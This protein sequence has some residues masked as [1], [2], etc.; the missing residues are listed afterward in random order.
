[1]ESEV[2]HRRLDAADPESGSEESLEPPI[3]EEDQRRGRDARSPRAIGW[4]GWVDILHRVFERVGHDHLG[5]IAAGVTFY[6]FFAIVPAMIALATLYGIVADSETLAQHLAILEGYLPDQGIHW[7]EDELSR[8]TDLREQGLTLTFLLS[9]A[10]SLWSMNNAVVAIFAAM[11]VAYREVE[12][13]SFITLYLETF[14]FTLAGLVFGLVLITAFVVLPLVLTAIGA[15]TDGFG[16]RLV[17]APILFVAVLIAS[18][19]IFRF[20]PSRRGARWTWISVGSVVVAGGWLAAA[21]LM[22]WYLSSIADYSRI[23]GSLGAIMAL[24]FWIYMSVYVLCLGG[25]L[26]AEIEHQTRIDTTI[27]P[28]KPLGKRGAFVADTIGKAAFD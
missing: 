19:A 8:I 17:M 6:I 25:E 16:G 9:V 14:L 11:N 15:S 21:V 2:T 7:L 12:R 10:I 3:S 23:Y 28:E 26:N 5:L 22:S 27:G 1:M 13:R 20:G 4:R 18:S 24:L